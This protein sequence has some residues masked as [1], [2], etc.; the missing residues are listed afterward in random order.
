MFAILNFIKANN[1]KCARTFH[2]SITSSLLIVFGQLQGHQVHPAVHQRL[3]NSRLSTGF[4][5]NCGFLD[6]PSCGRWSRLHYVFPQGT[7]SGNPYS[8][9]VFQPQPAHRRFQDLQWAGNPHLAKQPGADPL[10][11]RQSFARW[12]E[13]VVGKS[14]AWTDE[15]L[16]TAGV[17]LLIYVR[18]TFSDPFDSG[19]T[20]SIP[21]GQIHHG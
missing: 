17:L 3:S 1:F 16:E 12:S 6:H 11:P 5:G 18:G 19:L 2:N 7:A 8:H 15:Q 9:V 13:S 20:R 21:A 14:K 4:P 10:E